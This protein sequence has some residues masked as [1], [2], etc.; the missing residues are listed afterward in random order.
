M[1]FKNKRNII[2]LILIFITVL[3]ISSCSIKKENPNVI[4]L[5]GKLD[6]DFKIYYEGIDEFSNYTNLHFEYDGIKTEV[7]QSM[8]LNIDINGL[9][10]VIKEDI[11]LDGKYEL[12]IYLL[13]KQRQYYKEK[14]YFLN[15]DNGS[16][17]SL[18]QINQKLRKDEELEIKPLLVKD[19]FEN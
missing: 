9:P 16:G 10:V 12:V 2:L 17:L 11:D 4:N 5:S 8:K 19:A 1:I 13:E 18:E 3:I 7:F 14:I 6:F 15:Y